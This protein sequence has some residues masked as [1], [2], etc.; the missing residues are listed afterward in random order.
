MT[1][2][3]YTT[4]FSSKIHMQ[5]AVTTFVSVVDM[6]VTE[7]WKSSQMPAYYVKAELAIWQNAAQ[8]QDSRMEV[9]IAFFLRNG[10]AD[11][12]IYSV[13]LC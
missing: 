7:R 6:Q 12:S 1:V 11:C 10:I 13:T 2:S 4:L 3:D 8:S 5:N 9:A